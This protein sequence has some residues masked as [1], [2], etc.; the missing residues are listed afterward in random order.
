MLLN[1]FVVLLSFG[2]INLIHLM[3]LL[4]LQFLDMERYK[5]NRVRFAASV[6][7]CAWRY[8]K[9]R[10][11]G[12]LQRY[13]A[14]RMLGLA[15]HDFHT[16]REAIL[17]FTSSFQESQFFRWTIERIQVWIY[18]PLLLPSTTLF[19]LKS[20]ASICSFCIFN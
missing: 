19:H 14:K 10:R 3:C 16:N 12:Y 1:P 8:Y 5:T 15:I 9:S 20:D 7:A 18:L 17:T 4:F 11:Q 6:I 2:L 13:Q